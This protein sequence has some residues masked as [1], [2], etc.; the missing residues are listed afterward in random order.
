MAGDMQTLN[1]FTKD[2]W[3]ARNV[4]RYLSNAATFRQLGK[5]I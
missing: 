2:K 1:I 3:Q 5:R 4:P